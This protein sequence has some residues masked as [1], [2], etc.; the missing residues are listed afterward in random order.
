MGDLDPGAKLLP[1]L[2]SGGTDARAVPG[3][4][5]YGFMPGQSGEDALAL[6]HGHDE[7]ARI[8]DLLFAVKSFHGII[9]RFAAT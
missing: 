5:V 6:A 3:I 8:D 9:T 1:F 2:V 7:R 4:K